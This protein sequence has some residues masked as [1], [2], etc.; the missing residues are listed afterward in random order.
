MRR[1]VLEGVLESV[2][3]VGEAVAIREREHG[4]LLFAFLGEID[5]RDNQIDLLAL[6]W[7]EVPSSTSKLTMAM[8]VSQ[9]WSYSLDSGGQSS[10]SIMG[11]LGCSIRQQSCRMEV[12]YK[13]W[14]QN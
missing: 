1:G 7:V 13:K 8:Q 5:M 4:D 12:K 11:L 9:R 2:L 3:V 6:V 10:L 14:D